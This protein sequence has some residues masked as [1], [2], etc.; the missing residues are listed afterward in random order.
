MSQWPWTV[1]RTRWKI[2]SRRVKECPAFGRS[3]WNACWMN[4]VKLWFTNPGEWISG[5]HCS[6][7]IFWGHSEKAIFCRPGRESWLVNQTDLPLDLGPPVPR[8]VRSKFLLFKIFSLWYFVMTAWA[9]WQIPTTSTAL[10]S[11]F[12]LLCSAGPLH[13]A[14]QLGGVLIACVALLSPLSNLWILAIVLPYLN[15]PEP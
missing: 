9:V 5:W 14:Y 2:L 8:T 13:P 7:L 10:T 3:S 15:H 1:T 6:L 12:C 11:D 4:T